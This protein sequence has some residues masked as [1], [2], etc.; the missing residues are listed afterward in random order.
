[1]AGLGWP[2][3]SARMIPILIL[4]AGQSSRMRGVDKLLEPVDGMPLLRRQAEMALELSDDVRV[5]LPPPPHARY[6]ELTDLPVSVIG[7]PDAAEGMGASLRHIFATLGPDVS[8][9]MLLLAD[10]PDLTADD[11]RTVADAVGT[12]PDALIWRGATASG[13]GGHPMVFARALFP[14]FSKLSGD[15]G[16]RGIVAAA[17][18]DV[19]L[20]PLAGNR[21]RADL[22][23]PEEWAAWRA[24]RHLT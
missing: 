19:V 16:G 5:A 8:H 22:D 6:A 10:L 23:T 12:R 14:A 9:A 13:Q 24:A 20:V 11:L 3:Y 21:A 4:A 15:D 1:M 17:G 7:V 2:A 18:G